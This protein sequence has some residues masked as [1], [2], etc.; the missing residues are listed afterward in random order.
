MSGRWRDSV[1]WAPVAA[2]GGFALHAWIVRN[3][4]LDDA[5]IFFRYADNWVA[6][7]GP[8][9]NVGEKVEG[10]TSFLWLVLLACGRRLGIETVFLARTL[11]LVLGVACIA[12]VALSHRW[13]PGGSA[14][15]SRLAALLLGT[16]GVFTAWPMSGM[17]VPLYAFLVTACFLV[18][19][20]AVATRT[21][22]SGNAP[23]AREP[24]LFGF[25][26]AL[27]AL[28]RPEGTLLFVVL[29][30]D[31]VLRRRTGA[32]RRDLAWSLAAFAAVVLPHL[33]WRLAYYG[34]PLPNTFY[35][36][37]G[38]TWRQVANGIVYSL[39]FLVPAAPLGL[40]FAIA[41]ASG[42]WQR[43]YPALAVLPAFLVLDAIAVVLVGGD[44]MPAFR[45]YA[46]VLPLLCLGAGWS[47]VA[48]AGE[49]RWAVPA[50]LLAAAYGVAGMFLVPDIARRIREDRVAAVGMIV[51]QWLGANVQPDALLATNTAGSVPY[52]SG[53]RTIDMLG[54]TDAHIA[55]RD[56]KGLG[57]SWVG[58]EK[59]DGAYV[60]ERRPDYVMFGSSLGSIQ[61]AFASDRELDAQP[62]FHQLYEPR[63][64]D[65]SLQ[66]GGTLSISL[67]RKQGLREP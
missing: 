4:M 27:L 59:A 36:K 51:G 13:I 6:G 10:Y 14:R 52:Y 29:L 38:G 32:W 55:H 63:V 66:G 60:L 34:Y 41:V 7:H 23:R 17:E 39:R 20:R 21:P 54:L 61:P 64:Y 65:L 40:P 58:H 37:V 15:G 33:A 25:A 62:L 1:W 49:R 9:Y 48:L 57:R 31:L 8:V 42:R 53:L 26:G 28:A 11:G 44:L 50:A 22:G 5:F 16:C 45:F 43:R 56:V 3:W 2:L 12:L 18:Y 24:L 67:W 30:A 19:V 47:L 46:P 35:A